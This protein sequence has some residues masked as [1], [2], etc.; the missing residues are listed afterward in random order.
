[1]TQENL[2]DFALSG[3]EDLMPEELPTFES[4]ARITPAAYRARAKAK[5]INA[6][7][8]QTLAEIL[9]ELPQEDEYIHIISNGDYDY[10]NFVP[11][12]V[13]RLGTIDEL[14]GSTWT[15]N[16]ANVENLLAQYDAGKIRKIRIITGLFFKRRETAV[17]ATLVEGLTKRGQKYVATEN[18][19]KVLLIKSGSKH[20]VVEGSANWTA[21]PRIEQNIVAQSKGLYDHHRSWMQTYIGAQEEDR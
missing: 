21:N 14:W 5:M 4:T 15:M 1:M 17:Y 10:Y 9:P 12:F 2:A 20:Y 13:E 19:A 3:T 16:R 18:H 11:L 8:E 6:M 7:R